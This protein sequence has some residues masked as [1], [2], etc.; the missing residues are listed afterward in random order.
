MECIL[1]GLKP[2]FILKKKKKKKGVADN[3]ASSQSPFMKR[4]M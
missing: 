1:G 2:F 4:A 3:V